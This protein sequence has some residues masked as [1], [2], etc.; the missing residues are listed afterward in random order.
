MKTMPHQSQD[1][2][3]A[4][5]DESRPP[6]DALLARMEAF[7]R[8]RLDAGLVLEPFA[9]ESSK[10]VY[11]ARLANG[12]KL[13]VKLC[14]AA[15]GEQARKLAADLDL[16]FVPKVAHLLPWSDGRSVLCQDW[17]EGEHVPPERM[18]AAQCTAWVAAYARF[19]AAL[20]PAHMTLAPLDTDGD[21][22]TVAAFARRHPLARPLLRRL[23]DIPA[24]ERRAAREELVPG[25]G[26][27]HY[28]QYLFKGDEIAAFLDFDGLMPTVPAQDIAYAVA[29]RYYKGRLSRADLRRLDARFRQMM[30]ELPYASRDWRRAINV[31]RLFV[32][33]RRL[34]AHARFAGAALIVARRD[35]ALRRMLSL[36]PES[37]GGTDGG[38][39][40][41]G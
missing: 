7:L 29:R 2:V 11:R 30:A 32:A 35:R 28:L 3:H 26:D 6:R 25:H 4:R 38:T 40:R 34:K 9:T 20:R 14:A 19:C 36:V 33:A 37:K 8:E 22:A 41:Q 21:H 31:Y 27:F 17:L 18:N 10:V 23:I 13:F 16:P 24:D 15:C 5:P 1:D 39:G 12:R